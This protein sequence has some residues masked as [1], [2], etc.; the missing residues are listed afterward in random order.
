VIVVDTNLFVRS[1][2]GTVVPS[3]DPLVHRARLLFA[4]VEAGEEEIVTNEAVI[5]EVVFILHMPRH[6]GLPRPDVS[7]R[8]LPMLNL[9]GC[10]LPEKERVLRAFPLWVERPR[11]SFVDALTATQALWTEQPLA[12][13]DAALAAVPGVRRW[14]EDS[15]R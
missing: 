11:I 12:T 3:D 14:P 7:E 6:Y 5:A 2:V 15:T 9:Q 4:A 1:L 10:H 13:F 8:M